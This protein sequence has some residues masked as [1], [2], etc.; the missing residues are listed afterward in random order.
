MAGKDTK[1][2]S[3]FAAL[4][5]LKETLPEG[6]P[7]DPPRAP[8]APPDRRFA[9]KIVVAR[10]RKGRGGRTVTCVRGIDASPEQLEAIARE[11][12]RALGC[13]ASVED[14]EVLVQGEQE[15]RVAAWLEAQG[16]K[17]IVIGT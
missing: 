2:A 3:P 16:A 8:P 15:P 14:G 1:A 11:L 4:A 13:G 9:G 5:A 17:R 7:P 10:S 12:K 6:R